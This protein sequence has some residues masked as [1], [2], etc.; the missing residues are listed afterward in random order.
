MATHSCTLRYDQSAFTV[1]W[2][3]PDLIRV[4]DTVVFTSQGSDGQISFKTE[5][6][7][8]FFA[9]VPD[10]NYYVVPQH[11]SLNVKVVRASFPWTASAPGL[12]SA[13]SALPSTKAEDTR[14]LVCNVR[15]VNGAV[16][17]D[18]LV[19]PGLVRV[20]DTIKFVNQ[21]KSTVT[22]EF[23]DSPFQATPGTT[24]FTVPAGGDESKTTVRSCFA[25]DCS[26]PGG[27]E[28]GDGGEPSGVG[29]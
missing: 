9:D 18:E 22:I 6:S 5:R 3:S 13:V 20:G 16:H 19:P 8:S 15:E 7:G 14:P 24:S 11:G 10:D 17:I 28:R 21:T 25:F 12:T 4:G 27:P 23:A 29:R 26:Q 2:G 1:T